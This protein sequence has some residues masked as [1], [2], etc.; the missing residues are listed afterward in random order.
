MALKLTV[1]HKDGSESRAVITPSTEVAFEE[2]FG[3][4]WTEAFSEAFP[5]N[6]YLY[7]AAWHSLHDEGKT[8]L[9]FK[10]W[11]RTMDSFDV[12][13]PEESPNPLDQALPAGS[14]EL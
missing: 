13:A 7:Y 9:E 8:G 14:S 4:A 11:L 3:K 1:K 12:E 10:E 5:K 2:H 6:Q